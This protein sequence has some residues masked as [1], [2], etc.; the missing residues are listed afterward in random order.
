MHVLTLCLPLLFKLSNG[1]IACKIRFF[2]PGEQ[3]TMLRVSIG[4]SLDSPPQSHRSIELGP[5]K[6]GSSSAGYNAQKCAVPNPT[7][8]TLLPK[9]R[10]G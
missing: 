5:A 8:R 7:P 6:L 1:V 2:I 3:G 10:N 4:F 9:Y